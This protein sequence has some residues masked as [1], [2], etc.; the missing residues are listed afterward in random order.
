MSAAA[1]D[2]Q[3]GRPLDASIAI[4][5]HGHFRY[6]EPC[7]ASIYEQTHRARF[8]VTLVDNIGESAIPELLQRRFPKVRLIVNERPLGFSENNNF[9]FRGSTSRYNFLLNPD[10]VLRENALDSLMDYMD[11]HPLAGACG[12]KLLY[13]DGT[14]QLSCRRFPSVG[15]VLLRRTPLRLLFRNSKTARRYDMTEWDHASCRPI[16]WLFGAAIF[17]RREAWESVGPLDTTMFLFCED[18]DWCLRCHRAGW[19]V[20]YVAH[21]VI[22]HDFNED[23]YNRYFTRS[24][25]A[26]YKTM[27]QF[28]LKYPRYCIRW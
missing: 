21:A 6:L 12:P 20:H 9:A 14:L 3:N 7:L 11:A 27:L 1:K 17:A 13:A 15:S 24:R 18:I 4:V 10:T 19:E 28:F 23:K 2:E 5:S 8:E 26:H 22:V 25:F 16:D